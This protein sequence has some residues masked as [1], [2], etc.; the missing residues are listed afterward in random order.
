MLASLYWLTQMG[1]LLFP[2]T[3]LIDP[4]F[5]HPGQPPAQLIVDGVMLGMLAIAAAL[6]TRSR[7]D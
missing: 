4:E 2:G 6:E 1:A 7:R 5:A 3:A